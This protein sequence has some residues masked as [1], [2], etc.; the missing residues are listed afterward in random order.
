MD[1]TIKDP[2]T[3]YDVYLF[4]KTG[5]QLLKKQINAVKYYKTKQ[6]QGGAQN[7]NSFDI[8]EN[9]EHTDIVIK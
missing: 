7:I 6:L 5:I 1:T 4:T 8:S 9:T 3:G 2:N